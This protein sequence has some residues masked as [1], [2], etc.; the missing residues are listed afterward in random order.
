MQ[1]PVVQLLVRDPRLRQALTLHLAGSFI[2]AAEDASADED[3]PRL[4]LTTTIDTKPELCA[5]LVATGN[6]VVVL[7]AVPRDHEQELYEAAGASHYLAM[8]LEPG[9]LDTALQDAARS[10]SPIPCDQSPPQT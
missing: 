2:V 1:Q 7:A 8:S 5:E 4:V 9:E 6:V 3:P 10:E